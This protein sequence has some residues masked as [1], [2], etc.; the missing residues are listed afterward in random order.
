MTPDEAAAVRK[1]YLDERKVL[2]EGRSNAIRSLEKT[3]VTL[4]AGALA[5]SI[6]F[7]HDIAP[8]PRQI[9]WM[10]ASWSLLFFSLL[11]MLVVFIAGVYVFDKDI[12]AW[13]AEYEKRDG[14]RPLCLICVLQVLEWTSLVSFILG[15]IYFAV[16]AV[17]NLPK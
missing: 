7:L 6:T 12:E 13:K 15:S 5:L 9:G 10:I 1:E 11:L 16:F 4:S 8:H 17:V 14:K 2:L 3:L